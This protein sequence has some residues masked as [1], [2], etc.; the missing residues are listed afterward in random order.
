MTFK[1]QFVVEVKCRGKILRV[2]DDIVRLP[3]GSEYSL[4]LK[5]LNS[6][7]ASVKISIDGEDVLDYQTLILQPNSSTELEGFLRG[8]N[9]TN[10]FKFINKTKEISDHRG[11][12]I[13]DG[14]IRVE[15][16]YEKAK[17]IRKVIL[18]DHHH[19]DHHH[20]HHRHHTYWN[21]NDWFSGDSTVKYSSTMGGSSGDGVRGM[22]ESNVTMD[23]LDD[24]P[25]A[26]YHVSNMTEVNS[27][28][29]ESLGQPLDD[30]GITVKG[31]ECNQAFRYGE[32][33]E[34]EQAEVITIRLKGI[35]GNDAPVQQPITVK[36]KLECSTCG[37]V[38]KSSAKFCANCRTFLQ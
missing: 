23:S 10:R 36:T 19:H 28:G 16:A 7:K 3:F 11:D 4:Y 6:R 5:N 33:G 31:S 13:D 24:S 26:A 20:H 25:V 14:I 21:Y 34:L 8:T 12:K 17:P 15:F 30:E 22:A 35:T 18:E 38:S 27:L 1:D 37:R 2:Q 32:I 29:A 9:A